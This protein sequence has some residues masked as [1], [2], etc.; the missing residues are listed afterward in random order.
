MLRHSSTLPE[1][2]VHFGVGF[3]FHFQ[4]PTLSVDGNA[5]IDTLRDQDFSLS[6]GLLSQYNQV[7]TQDQ[8]SQMENNCSW[9]SCCIL[10][11]WD[12]SEIQGYT[13]NIYNM[14]EIDGKM[15]SSSQIRRSSL[16][17]KIP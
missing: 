15:L 12:S 7:D 8:A 16:S 6:L 13:I 4:F 17:I 10:G 3:P 14:N 2:A 5:L 1:S 9:T 11:I